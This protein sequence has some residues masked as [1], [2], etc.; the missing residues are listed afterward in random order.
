M[1]GFRRQKEL[2]PYRNKMLIEF[3]ILYVNFCFRIGIQNK[4]WFD[5]QYVEGAI[6]WNRFRRKYLESSGDGLPF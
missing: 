6:W 3:E 2:Y 4:T 5:V 1:Y